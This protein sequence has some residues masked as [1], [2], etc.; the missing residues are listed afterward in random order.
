[1]TDKYGIPD[2]HIFSSRDHSFAAGI[3]QMTSGRGADVVLNS[4]AGSLLQKS[5]NCV[6]RFGR[7]VEIGKRDLEGNSKLEMEVF[8]RQVAFASVDLLQMEEFKGEWVQRA[9][10]SPMHLL[11]N[12]NI[13]PNEPIVSYPLAEVEK[14]FRLMQ[15]GKHMGKFVLTVRPD[16]MV[17][18]C[19]Y[20]FA[21]NYYLLL[22]IHAQV[23]QRKLEASLRPDASDLIVGRLGGMGRSICH[24][25]A[26]K[27]AENIIVMSRSAGSS[28]ESDE[29]VEEM[30]KLGV[31]LLPV[32]C[33][34]SD[35][36]ALSKA[37]EESGKIMP[38][39]RGVVQAAM[40]L[41][42]SSDLPERLDKIRLC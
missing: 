11:R 9:L 29:I 30:R 3:M 7:F 26:D 39:V 22:I 32:S 42:V 31:K 40:V 17:P 6:A 5:L 2:D 41:N 15:A 21:P 14:P 4:L 16:E 25:M 33:D 10:K 20:S 8:K 34:V 36:L 19:S 27:G 24:W 37:V 35:P 1:M 18:V 28:R 38:P 13:V 23:G 12:G